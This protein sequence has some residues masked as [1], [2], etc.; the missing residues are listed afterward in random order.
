MKRGIL[1]AKRSR[2]I[3][4]QNYEDVVRWLQSTCKH[5]RLAEAPYKA[6]T[7]DSLPPMR[8]CLDCG[9]TEEGW[10]PGNVVLKGSA[11][12]I[13]REAVYSIRCGYMVGDAD[14]GPLLRGET[15]VQELIRKG[16]CI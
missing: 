7:F 10:G 8:V 1:R 15:T 11:R 16:A 4:R 13:E 6:L 12:P 3:A 14:K 2:A 5:R 9:L